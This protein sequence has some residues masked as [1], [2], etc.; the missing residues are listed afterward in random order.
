MRVCAFLGVAVGASA[1]RERDAPHE[2]PLAA[3]VCGMEHTGTTVTSQ[4]IMSA[5]GVMGAVET[6]FL[7]ASKPHDFQHIKPWYNWASLPSSE[8]WL[9]LDANER[10]AL[11]RAR[12][13]SDMY[14][15]VLR[16][17]PLLRTTTRYV[18]KT[19]RYCYDLP[20]IVR[21]A[22]GVPV[23][24]VNKTRDRA[25]RS[26]RGRGEQWD[27]FE[28]HWNQFQYSLLEVRRLGLA[29]LIYEVRY[30]D[31]FADDCRRVETGARLFEFLGLPF[32]ASWFHG[33]AINRKHGTSPSFKAQFHGGFG[34]RPLNVTCVR[35]R[36]T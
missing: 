4:L 15:Y 30:E 8:G 7:L 31:L 18:D 22:P 23:V 3:I 10:K 9:G 17:S 36:L 29:D 14:D 26:R 20:S 21:R 32:D 16:E 11:L 6:G 28:K 33:D 34:L 13:H 12:T 24:V 1:A 19:P 5:P 25:W 35:S 2:S 27:E